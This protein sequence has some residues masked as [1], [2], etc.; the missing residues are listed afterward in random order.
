MTQCVMYALN[1][2]GRD[3][4][5]RLADGNEEHRGPL[6]IRERES[7]GTCKRGAAGGGIAG[8]RRDAGGHWRPLVHQNWISGGRPARMRV[9]SRCQCEFRGHPP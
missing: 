1:R 8:T 7:G 4:V 9:R 6:G 3:R 2:L 5:P